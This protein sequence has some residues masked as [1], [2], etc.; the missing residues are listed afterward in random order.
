MRFLKTILKI[1]V[2]AFA[3][4]II[5]VLTCDYLVTSNAK[6]KLYDDVEAIPY[7]EVGLL[8]GT[9]PQTRI[10][11]V[12]N[13]FFVFRID[14]AEKLY[15]AG[16]IS[17][18]LISGDEDSLD[19]VNEV[20]SMKEALMVRGIPEHAIML[21]GKGFRTLES[22]VRANK[23]F[24]LQSFTLISQKFHNERALYQANHLDLDIKDPIAFNAESPRSAMALIT[25][26]REYLA[27]VKLFLDIIRNGS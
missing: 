9:T 25:Y 12:V 2:I 7:R 24:D 11:R 6:G 27:R 3:A 4:I 19:G 16:K 1:L 22:I 21:D 17:T 26:A 14:A 10:G 20:E 18:I 5:L 23:V 13:R 8:L 15:K